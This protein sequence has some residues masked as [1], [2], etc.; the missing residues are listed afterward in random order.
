MKF[1][2]STFLW[3]SPF[4]TAS[5]DLVYKV[6]EMGF[7]IIEI[8]VEKKE[9]I[10]WKKLKDVIK[11]TGLQV[12]ISGAFGADRDI[13]HEDPAI[14][15]KGAQY[16]IDCIQIAQDMGSP[17]FGGPIYSAVGKTRF[18]SDD[19]KKKERAWCVENLINIGKVAGDHGI[20]VG[21][22]PL[23][24]FETD[25]VNTADQAI[26]LVREAGSPHIKIQLD[27]FHTNIEEKNIADT[28]RSVGKDLLCHVQGNE[29]DRGT[30]GTGNVDWTGIATAL[31]EIGYDDAI[32]I[33]T[34]G[35]VSEEIARAA[36]IWRPLANSSDELAIEGL[37]FYKKLFNE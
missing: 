22:E 20:V 28:I 2:V 18:T 21:L 3:T 19:Q 6:K 29:S 13:S 4:R 34:F 17:I 30:P 32:V 24:R 14:R 11:E 23:N 12:T 5:F 31:K 8:A 25:M 26:S 10:D 7:D 37:Q 33:E 35:E 1:G 9:L 27:T 36:S 16:I 15:K